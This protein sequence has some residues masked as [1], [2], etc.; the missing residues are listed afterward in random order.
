MLNFIDVFDCRRVL[1]IG[2]KMN[3][4]LHARGRPMQCEWTSDV[5]QFRKSFAVAIRFTCGR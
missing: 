3:L 4:Q 5:K 2:K 1:A